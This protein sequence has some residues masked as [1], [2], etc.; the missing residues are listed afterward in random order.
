MRPREAS[1]AREDQATESL[2]RRLI[3]D[4]MYVTITFVTARTLT[5][6]QGL[7]MWKIG[8]R[9]H[10]AP[11]HRTYV[12]TSDSPVESMVEG[13]SGLVELISITLGNEPIEVISLKANM[14]RVPVPVRE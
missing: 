14:E 4:Q 6:E 10:A 2:Q 13:L 7:E 11:G 3:M 8:S 9:F 1:H 5:Q 12:L